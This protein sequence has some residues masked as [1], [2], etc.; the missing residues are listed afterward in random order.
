MYR[1]SSIILYHGQQMR[2]YRA[3]TTVAST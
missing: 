1:A 2:T 3:S